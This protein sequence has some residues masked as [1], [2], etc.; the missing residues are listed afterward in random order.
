MMQILFTTD[1]QDVDIFFHVYAS[2]IRIRLNKY[3]YLLFL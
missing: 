3:L 1:S 2:T